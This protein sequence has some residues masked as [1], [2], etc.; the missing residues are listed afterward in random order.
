MRLGA[1]LALTAALAVAASVPA[2][3]QPRKKENREHFS[4]TVHK[5]RSYLDA[6]TEVRPGEKGY[7][8]YYYYLT[9]Q[10][11]T[12]GPANDSRDFRWPLP[13]RFELPG[14]GF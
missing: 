9:S 4:I 2:D 8:E 10:Y 13:E 7:H 14:F 11:P 5:Q 1:L 3:A 12:Y 6:G